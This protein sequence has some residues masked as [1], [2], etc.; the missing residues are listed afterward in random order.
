MTATART[1]ELVQAAA[2]AAD[3]VMGTDIVGLDVSERLPLTDAFLLATGTSERQV[4]AIARAIEDDLFE[5]GA[6]PLRREGRA[7]GRWVL[8]D[9][10]DLVVH[11][12]HEDERQ[13]YQ[14]ER[15]WRDC[16]AIALDLPAAD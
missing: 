5:L 15:L 11:V 12:F 2:K 6:K 1:I 14:L 16:P 9:L 4:S 8:I 3:G 10:G 7:D 13:Y